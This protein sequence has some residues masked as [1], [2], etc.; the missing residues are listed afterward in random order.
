M[1]NNRIF[2]PKS[3]NPNDASAWFNIERTIANRVSQGEELYIFAGAFGNNRDPQLKTRV[4]EFYNEALTSSRRCSPRQRGIP[5]YSNNRSC[6]N[7]G[8]VDTSL[9]SAGLPV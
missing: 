3:N 9:E 5:I 8:W 7:S 1:D 2:I 4:P 6:S